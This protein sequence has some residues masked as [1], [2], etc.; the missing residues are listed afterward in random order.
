[1]QYYSVP[2][3]YVHYI[4]GSMQDQL[5]DKQNG[6]NLQSNVQIEM[7]PLSPN[8]NDR[9]D[10]SDATPRERMVALELEFKDLD[11]GGSD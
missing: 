7:H 6:M 8:M 3:T 11:M 1:M 10:S 9:I 5:I 4:V 2:P